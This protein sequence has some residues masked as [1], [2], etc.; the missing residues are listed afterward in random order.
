[1]AFHQEFE[2]I[3]EDKL[4][5]ENIQSGEILCT[6]RSQRNV[7]YPELEAS[8]DS[9]T[10]GPYYIACKEF[11]QN[12]NKT[13]SDSLPRRVTR[14]AWQSIKSV[15][16]LTNPGLSQQFEVERERMLKEGKVDEHGLV[17]ETLLFHGS[18]NENIN[19]IVEENFSVGHKPGGGR[20]KAMLFGRGLYMSPLPGVSL[21]YG[22]TLLLC[23]VLLGKCQTYQPTGAPPPEIPEEFDS[24]VIMRDG[25]AVVIVLKKPQQIL[26]FC[27]INVKRELFSQAGNINIIQKSCKTV[28]SME[29]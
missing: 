18:E 27:I 7:F 19:I 4:R 21:M 16:H 9:Q 11:Y 26:P 29:K 28:A 13:G 6:E 1:V 5:E 25:I 20:E 2:D 24:R 17:R 10:A 8:F 12:I 23:K 22:D 15:V 3:E 14:A